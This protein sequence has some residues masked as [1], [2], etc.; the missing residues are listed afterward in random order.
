MTKQAYSEHAIEQ[1]ILEWLNLEG[2]LAWKLKDSAS[3]DPGQK[4]FLTPGGFRINGVSDVVA[5]KDGVVLFLEVKTEKG[6]QSDAQKMFEKKLAEK[7]GRYFVVRSL[8]DVKGIIS[9]LQWK[10]AV[11]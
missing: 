6:R 3:Y 10:S 7:G 2:W 1:Q 4:K 11:A 8:D 9:L 5:V